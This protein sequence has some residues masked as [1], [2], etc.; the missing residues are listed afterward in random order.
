MV[1]YQRFKNI[2]PRFIGMVTKRIW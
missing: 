2:F 1:C